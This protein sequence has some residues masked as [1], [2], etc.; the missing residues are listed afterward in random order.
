MSLHKKRPREL[1]H[2]VLILGAAFTLRTLIMRQIAH[3]SSDT[4]HPMRI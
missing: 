4:L 1:N 2:G 3:D